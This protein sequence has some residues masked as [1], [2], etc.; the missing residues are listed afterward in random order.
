MQ[1]PPDWAATP[2]EQEEYV[3]HEMG[4]RQGVEAKYK[5]KTWNVDWDCQLI[6]SKCMNKRTMPMLEQVLPMDRPFD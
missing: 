5:I 6:P 3:L 2:H 4:I 1:A